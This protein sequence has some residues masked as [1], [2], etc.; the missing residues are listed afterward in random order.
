MGFALVPEWIWVPPNCWEWWWL[1]LQEHLRSTPACQSSKNKENKREFF[2]PFFF[3]FSPSKNRNFIDFPLGV[4]VSRLCRSLRGAGVPCTH[5][6]R[7]PGQLRVHPT[8]PGHPPIQKECYIMF[9]EACVC[10]GMGLRNV[11]GGLQ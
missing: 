1:T 8:A 11:G 10:S 9:S 6:S 3:F 5:T 7:P 2:F 4:P